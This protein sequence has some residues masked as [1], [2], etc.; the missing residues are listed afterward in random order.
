MIRPSWLY[1]ERDRTTLERL[2]GRLEGRQG[3]PDRPRR[4]PPER[5]LRRERRRRGDPRRRRPG[6]GRR[7]VQHHP[8]GADHPARSSSRLFVEAIGAPPIRRRISYRLTFAASFADRGHR[9]GEGPE[10]P[11]LITRY[12]TWLMGRDLSYST[13]KAEARARL[14]ARRSAT[15]RASSG[16][17]AGSSRKSQKRGPNPARFNERNEKSLR[18]V[19]RWPESPQE[20][21]ITPRSTPCSRPRVD[22]AEKRRSLAAWVPPGS[23]PSQEPGQVADHP[24]STPFEGGVGRTFDN[25]FATRDG[26]P[27]MDRRI[28]VVDDNELICQQLSQTPRQARPADQGGPRRDH[29]AWSG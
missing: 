18:H 11:P 9:P 7:G 12:A 2:V 8:P 25:R 6:L 3:P 23:G 26:W 5:H 22:R 4:Q 27:A 24:T 10:A 19:G 28:L 14:D 21:P 17:S 15:A 1:G 20:C 13:A 16:R 29:R